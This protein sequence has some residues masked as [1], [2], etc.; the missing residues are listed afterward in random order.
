MGTPL[1]KGRTFTDADR[2][3]SPGVVI[4]NEYWAR[5]LFQDRNPIGQFLP[6]GETRKTAILAVKNSWQTGYD[7]PRERTVYPYRQYMFGNF[8]ATIV[9][10]TSGEPRPCRYAPERDLGRGSQRAGIEDRNHG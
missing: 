7:Q 6:S 2:A 8:L 1:L 9:T 5:Q 10:R 4:I 3:D